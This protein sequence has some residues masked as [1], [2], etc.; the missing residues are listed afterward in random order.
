MDTHQVIERLKAEP[1]RAIVARE[2]G[3]DYMYLSRLAWGKTIRPSAEKIDQL[4]A[5]YQ[6]KDAQQ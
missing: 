5:Y 3:M 6:R 1:N 2:T 4:R